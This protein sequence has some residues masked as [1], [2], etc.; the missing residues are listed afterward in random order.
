MKGFGLDRVIEPKGNV[1]VAAWKLDNSEKLKSKELK[2]SVNLIDFER[3]NFNQIC[4]ICQ[5]DESKIKERI[6]KI[7]NERNKLHN[8]YTESSGL[9]TGI[10]EEI[11]P[12]FEIQEDFCEGDRVVCITPLA[13]MPLNI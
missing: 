9:F 2:I 3:G 7:V 12:D 10:I 13:G 6:F 1:P 8:P 11:S 5:Y 4:S